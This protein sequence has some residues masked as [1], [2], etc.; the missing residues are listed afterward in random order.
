MITVVEIILFIS[1]CILMLIFKC[2]YN[3]Y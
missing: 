2:N 1:A 3:N